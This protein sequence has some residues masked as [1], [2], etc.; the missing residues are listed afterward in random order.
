M[1]SLG[2]LVLKIREA[3]ASTPQPVIDQIRR[4]LASH[5]PIAHEL[6]VMLE[7]EAQLKG[8]EVDRYLEKVQRAADKEDLKKE[9]SQE[10]QRLLTQFGYI[11][12]ITRMRL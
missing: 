12:R 8:M 4:K 9:L 3:C 11:L 6:I 1:I 5:G 7:N 10:E 2:T